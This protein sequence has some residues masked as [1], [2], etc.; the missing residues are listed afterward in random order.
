MGTTA[1]HVTVLPGERLDNLAERVYGDPGKYDLLLA[2]NP[3][4]DIWE[5]K[6]GTVIEVPDA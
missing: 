4:L 5:P 6:A 2:A 3:D 1:R